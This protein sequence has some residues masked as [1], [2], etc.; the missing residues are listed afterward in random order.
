MMSKTEIL[1]LSDIHFRQQKGDITFR[2]EIREKMIQA[3]QN[4][5]DEHNIELDVVAVTGDIA[6]SAKDHEY[7]EAENFFKNLQKILPQKSQ[8]LIVPGNHDVDRKGVSSIHPLHTV[9]KEGLKI[10]ELLDTPE[11]IG[12]Y[13]SPKFESFRAFVDRIHPGLYTSTNDYYWVKNFP[14]KD[15]SFLGLNSSWAC[16]SSSDRGNITLGYPQV[17]NAFRQSKSKN[18]ILLMHHPFDWFNEKDFYRYN[19][20]LEKNCSLVL[21]G[22][23]HFDNARVI[24]TPSASYIYL[25]ANASYTKA[26]E[27]IIGFQFISLE[28]VS[29]GAAVTVY[30]YKLESR[31]GLRFVHDRD[32]WDKQKGEPCFRMETFEDDEKPQKSKTKK[33]KREFPPGIPK[34][35]KEWVKKFHSKIESDPFIKKGEGDNVNL[36]DVY[37]SIETKNP[38]Y[39]DKATWMTADEIRKRSRQKES[40]QVD[41][42]YKKKT[43]IDIEEL[44]GFK[45]CILLQGSA[46]TGKTTLS[47]HLAYTIIH[48]TCMDSLKGYLLVDYPGFFEA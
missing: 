7:E 39:I 27:L 12:R 29:K 23:N 19:G 13:I 11:E 40:E 36:Q 45:K 21:Y 6:F 18:K 34:E 25:G 35:Y 17:T 46:G 43:F 31:D 44:V 38:F 3:V 10:D 28:Y 32:R 37:I 15:V 5:L 20:E 4:H 42:K 14:G 8:I 9:V 33:T 47:K 22:H 24:K 1:H 2:Q 26:K 30:P 41:E 48:D 16:E